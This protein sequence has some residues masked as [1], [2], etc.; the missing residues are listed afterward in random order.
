MSSI[1]NAFDLYTKHIYDQEKI[2]LLKEYNLK[3]A[4]SVSSVMWELFGA[5]LTGQ[6]AEGITGA[7][8]KGWEIKSAKQGGSYEYQYHLNTGLAKLEEDCLVN[9]LFCR[10]SAEYE[11]VTVRM[12]QGSTLASLYFNKWKPAYESNYDKNAPTGIRQQRFRKNISHGFVER[13]GE[14][15]LKIENGKLTYRNDN[16]LTRFD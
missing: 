5:V 15:I 2:A 6:K 12:I 10:Y 16:L 9:H 13:E 11:N 4:G 1:D 8:L 7:D 14:L 3:I